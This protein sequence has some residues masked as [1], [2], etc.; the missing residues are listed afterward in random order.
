MSA[1]RPQTKREQFR[2]NLEE[3][4]TRLMGSEDTV[5][6][7]ANGSPVYAYSRIFIPRFV[8]HKILDRA[9]DSFSLFSFLHI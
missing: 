7:A 2:G 5:D 6:E 8:E 3:Y 9:F 1:S 4:L